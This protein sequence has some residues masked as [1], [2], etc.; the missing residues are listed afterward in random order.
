MKSILIA[1]IVMLTV[2]LHSP[3][4]LANEA[5]EIRAKAEQYYASENYK[6]AFK[7]YHKL[8]K[9]G[10]GYSQRRVSHMYANGEGKSVDLVDAYAWAALAAANND[11][12]L[13]QLDQELLP[14]IKDPAKARKEAAKLIKK[15]GKKAQAKRISRHNKRGRVLDEGACTGS[16]LA[17]PRN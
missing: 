15:Y 3:V 10:D 11:E 13:A 12:K 4:L 17:C 5:K 7:Q 6:K 14:K 2:V 9:F 8:A 1:V 16:K